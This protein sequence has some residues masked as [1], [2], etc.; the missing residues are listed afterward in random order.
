[1]KFILLT[2]FFF[3]LFVFDFIANCQETKLPLKIKSAR[4]SSRPMVFYISGD[5]GWNSFDKKMANEYET[6]GMPYVALNSFRYFWTK[7]NPDKLVKDIVPVINK[8]LIEWNKKEIIMIGYSFGAEI[9]PFL[10]NKL[11]N[12]LKEKVEL[13][14]L[15]TPSKTTDFTIHLHDMLL[16][17]G[18][19]K[20]DV[21]AEISKISAPNII[22]FFGNRETSIFKKSYQQKN[23]KI[24]LVKGGH[25]FSDSK[26]VMNQ[27]LSELKLK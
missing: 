3:S 25:V 5:G 21:A 9:M 22:C 15:I 17:D 4:I 1:M 27:V 11:P 23:L 6:N 24:F 18:K 13:I 14:I 16:L 2:I 8:Y 20:N 7:K 26:T 10:I 19:Y 12:D